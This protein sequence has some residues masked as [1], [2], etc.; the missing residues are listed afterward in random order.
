MLKS[1]CENGA[2]EAGACRRKK[3]WRGRFE[4]EDGRE[5]N[6]GRGRNGTLTSSEPWPHMTSQAE[7]IQDAAGCAGCVWDKEL[8]PG[9][10]DRKDTQRHA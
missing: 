2:K 6:E 10:F 5:R 9:N 8:C 3:D 7:M 1:G 4:V